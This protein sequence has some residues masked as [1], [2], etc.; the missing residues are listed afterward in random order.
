MGTKTDGQVTFEGYNAVMGGLT[1]DNKPIPGW[2]EVGD[3]VRNGWEGAAKALLQKKQ[4]EKAALIEKLMGQIM[5]N[6]MLDVMNA[7][8]ENT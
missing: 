3:R 6:P 4:E 7:L 5:S 1:W 2:D 8:V